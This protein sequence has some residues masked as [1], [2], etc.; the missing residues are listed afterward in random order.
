MAPGTKGDFSRF[1]PTE[2]AHFSRFPKVALRK[3]PTEVLSVGRERP[4]ISRAVT[5]GTQLVGGEWV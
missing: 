3:A 1:G 5:R 2:P 4:S